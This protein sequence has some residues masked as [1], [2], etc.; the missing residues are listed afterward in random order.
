MPNVPLIAIVED[1]EAVREALAGLL[2]VTGFRSRCFDRAEA[3]LSDPAA[4]GFDCLITDMRMPGID[5]LELQRRVRALA[6]GMPV[7]FITSVNDPATRKLALKGGAHAYLAKP[8]ADEIIL[9][10]L[11]SALAGGTP[12][13][14][15]PRDQ[16][17]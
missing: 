4:G 7:I 8:I 6:P 17:P 15:P 3:F 12:D 16:H 1:D 5:G 9:A 10:Q 11:E 13:L 14:E 2:E